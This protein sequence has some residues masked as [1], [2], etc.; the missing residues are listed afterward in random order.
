MKNIS[1]KE[2]DSTAEPIPTE[3]PSTPVTI[4]ALGPSRA[5]IP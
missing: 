2:N 3:P 4:D 1:L 5:A